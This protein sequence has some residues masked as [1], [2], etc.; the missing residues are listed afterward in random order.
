MYKHPVNI[1]NNEGYVTMTDV[2]KFRN[3]IYNMYLDDSNTKYICYTNECVKAN[4]LYI[5][6]VTK[7]TTTPLIVGET[8]LCYKTVSN[9]FKETIFTNSEEYTV[10]EIR[11]ERATVISPYKVPYY[12]DVTKVKLQMDNNTQGYQE[13]QEAYFVKSDSYNDYSKMTAECISY[14]KA[15]GGKQY[16]AMYYK[17]VT[18]FLLLDNVSANDHVRSRD[19]DYNYAITAHKSQ[20]STYQNIIV[21]IKDMQVCV[22]YPTQDNYI[23]FYKMIYTALSRASKSA[24]IYK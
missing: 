9:S 4:N 18:K 19:F 15:N 10:T 3:R 6:N 12:L 7:I 5:R 23:N 17:F 8:L 13:Y 14:A 11:E 24:I 16:W 22:R 1:K 2:D 21:D 20:G